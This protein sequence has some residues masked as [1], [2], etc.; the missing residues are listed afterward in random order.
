MHCVWL[1]YTIF[2]IILLAHETSEDPND[3]DNQDEF[4]DHA[5]S[6]DNHTDNPG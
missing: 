3:T 5:N 1:G 6:D 2:E 4:C